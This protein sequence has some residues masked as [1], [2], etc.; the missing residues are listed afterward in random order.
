MR[1]LADLA[2]AL[3]EVF[4]PTPWDPPERDETTPQSFAE[5]V[6]K[7]KHPTGCDGTDNCGCAGSAS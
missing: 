7:S 5:Y 1:L 6:A 3:R 2:A 4:K